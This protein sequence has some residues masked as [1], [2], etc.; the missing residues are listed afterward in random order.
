MITIATLGVSPDRGG[1]VWIT[2]P[3]GHGNLTHTAAIVFDDVDEEYDRLQDAIAGRYLY[4]PTP[5]AAAYARSLGVR[6][7]AIS[8]LKEPARALQEAV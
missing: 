4:A 8:N 5:E 3:V 6:P 1:A 7:A 2:G